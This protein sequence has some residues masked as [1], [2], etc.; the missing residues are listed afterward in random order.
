LFVA[1]NNLLRTVYKNLPLPLIIKQRL[2]HYHLDR[3]FD[4]KQSDLRVVSPAR[5]KS[6]HVLERS[7]PASGMAGIQEPSPASRRLLVADLHIP[8]PDRDSGSVRMWAIIRLLVEMGFRI[9]FICHSGERL[10]S[11]EEA[12]KD[13]CVNIL[14]GFDEACRHLQD[15]GGKYDFVLL[16]RPAVA[17]EYLLY[18]RACAPYATIIYDT[19]DLHWIRCEREMQLS[20]DRK[21][22]RIIERSRRME[23]LNAAGADVVFAIT[24]EE[25]NRLL[26]EQSDMNVVV[27]PNIHEPYPPKNPFRQRSGLMFIGGFRHKPNEDAVIHF[28]NDILPGIVETLPDVVFNII[29][30]DMPASIKALRSANV[31]PVGFV[32]DVAPYF[33][34]CRLFVAP[35][36]F[37]AGMKGK[38]GQ[39]M[40]HGLPVVATSIGVEGMGLRH[41]KHVLIAN[42]TQ[43]FA[44]AVARLYNDENLWNSLS[45]ESFSHLEAN[46][47]VVAVRKQMAG[48]FG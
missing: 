36:R 9:T 47:S 31:E 44:A 16:S 21:L 3:S 25:R 13:Q 32:P 28:V 35:L 46:Y 37:G 8:T 7:V 24:D 43:D 15:E 18:A 34:S 22:A 4:F 39:S 41:E 19:V 38:V 10:P 20:G 40:S 30:S 23:L 6:L 42:A 14:Y 33:E 5:I 17:F 26:A 2:K 12:L 11:Y 27:L 48:I 29:G 45:R 1:F